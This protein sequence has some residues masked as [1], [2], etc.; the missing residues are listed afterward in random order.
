MSHSVK[1]ATKP[2][3]V[4]DLLFVSLHWCKHGEIKAEL[5]KGST[6]FKAT[7]AVLTPALSQTAQGQHHQTTHPLAT[8]LDSYHVSFLL[9]LLNLLLSC[10]E[11][12]VHALSG[13]WSLWVLCWI[14]V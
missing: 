8:L 4:R 5:S 13:V 9:H 10:L 6:P 12:S 14:L 3:S 2:E 11:K 7:P 1:I